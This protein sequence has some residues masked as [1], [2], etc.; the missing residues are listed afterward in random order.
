MR[1]YHPIQ[2]VEQIHWHNVFADR[3]FWGAVGVVAFV[4]LFTAVVIIAAKTGN[5]NQPLPSYP[6]GWPY[7]PYG[8]MPIP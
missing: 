4:I 7:G 6:G 2:R 5:L 8:P 1:A 3:R